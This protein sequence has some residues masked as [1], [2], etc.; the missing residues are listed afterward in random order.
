[1]PDHVSGCRRFTLYEALDEDGNGMLKAAKRAVDQNGSRESPLLSASEQMR[2]EGI[3]LQRQHHFAG[4][5]VCEARFGDINRL[6]T[7]RLERNQKKS[8]SCCGGRR[9]LFLL[10][11]ARPSLTDLLSVL[12]PSKMHHQVL[13]PYKNA[14]QLRKKFSHVC[15]GDQERSVSPIA[16][17]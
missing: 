10:L 16:P 2:R 15:G 14:L 3:W 6:L 1:M 7:M 13:I 17:T 11:A 5:K 9:S 12:T 4:F 8:R